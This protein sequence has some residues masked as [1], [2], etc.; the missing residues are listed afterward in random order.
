VS[1][2]LTSMPFERL[3]PGNAE[4]QTLQRRGA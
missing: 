4:L 2:P 1:G 3:C